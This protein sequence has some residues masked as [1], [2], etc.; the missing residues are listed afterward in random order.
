MKSWTPRIGTLAAIAVLALASGCGGSNKGSGTAG[1]STTGDQST[2]QSGILRIGTVDAITS[3]NPFI[4]LSLQTG[5][6][7]T[8]TYAQLVGLDYDSARGFTPVPGFAKSW[9]ISNG[10]KTITFHTYADAKFSDGKPM[11]AEDAAWS[12]N[13]ILR[14]GDGPTG[15]V[16]YLLDGITKAT[17]PDPTTV[18]V[19]YS[20]PHSNALLSLAQGIP[21]LPKHIW[22]QYATGNGR[23]LRTYRPESQSGGLVSGGPYLLKQYE[24]R[25]TTVYVPNPNWFGEP[26][27]AKAVALTYYTNEDSMVEDFTRGQLDMIE[28]V[29]VPAL[30]TLESKPDVTMMSADRGVQADLFFN[31]N[32]RK[33]KNR[34]LLDPRVRRAMDECINRDEIID[35]V[36]QGHAKKVETLVGTPG[37]EEQDTSLPVTQYDCAAGNRVLDQLGYKRGSDG[38]RVA[39]ATSGT[40]AQAAHPMSYE[41][42]TVAGAGEYNVD[43][44]AEIIRKDLQQ[45]GVKVVQKVAGDETATNTYLVGEDCDPQT[46]KGYTSWDLDLAY[47]ISEITALDTLSGELKESWCAWNFTG[48]DNPAYDKLWPQAA[49]EL[50]Q[51]K[52]RQLLFKMQQ[53]Y[54]DSRATFPLA[55]KEEPSAYSNGWT[56][57]VRPELAV[58]ST[59]YYTAPQQVK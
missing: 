3:F 35:V 52:R 48:T 16:S 27:H 41:V 6:A 42:V 4:A 25:G 12:L 20:A 43:R 54:Y 14:Y 19:N 40:Y 28:S 8:A 55:E 9:D 37:G 29:P 34:E 11:T 15:Q 26:S 24:R 32:P 59:K 18:V 58:S 13:M 10:G 50:N 5:T 23:G 38:V 30:K 53:I 7:L 51:D 39:P 31:S 46:S 17:A 22:A 45:L 56:G 2:A 44:T 57:F 21:V 47:S 1:G 33:P 49:R 36:F